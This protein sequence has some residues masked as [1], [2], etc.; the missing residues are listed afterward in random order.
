MIANRPARVTH[1]VKNADSERLGAFEV[2][3]RMQKRPKEGPAAR[4]GREKESSCNAG[5]AGMQYWTDRHAMPGW[6]G[7]STQLAQRAKPP[8]RVATS[9]AVM[10]RDGE[11]KMVPT[12]PRKAASS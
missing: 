5:L 1:I 9:L 6:P 11:T 10:V 4:P 2:V 8:Y 7:H 12:W 3:R